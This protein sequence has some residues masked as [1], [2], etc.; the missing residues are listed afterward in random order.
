M[1]KKML[2]LSDEKSPLAAESRE[3]Y[4]ANVSPN[5]AAAQRLRQEAAEDVGTRKVC[6][7]ARSHLQP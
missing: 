7:L 6:A 1:I 2:K 4:A 5:E 3:M